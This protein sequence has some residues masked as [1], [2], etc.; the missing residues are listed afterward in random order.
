M[1][2]TMVMIV[3]ISIIASEYL[4]GLIRVHSGIIIV[5][6]FKFLKIIIAQVPDLRFFCWLIQLTRFDLIFV[7]KCIILFS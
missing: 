7:K 1:M 2:V 6:D 5:S 4:F 3:I